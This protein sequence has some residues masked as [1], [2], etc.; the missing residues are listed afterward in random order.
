MFVVTVPTRV[1][2]GLHVRAIGA[3]RAWRALACGCVCAG[4]LA[5]HALAAHAAGAYV[6]E[7]TGQYS[8]HFD[9]TG[10]QPGHGYSNEAEELFSWDVRFGATAAGPRSRQ[11]VA[12]L[13]AGGIDRFAR[14]GHVE[15][16]DAVTC[17]IAPS[18]SAQPSAGYFDVEPG[19]VAGTVNVRAIIP[20]LTGPTGQVT[21]A[22]SSNDVCAGLDAAGSAV[23][24]DPFGCAWECVDFA[25]NPAFDEAWAISLTGAPVSSFPRSFQA[26]EAMSPCAETATAYSAERS[27]SATLDILAVGSS[28]KP[29]VKPPH[30]SPAREPHPRTSHRASRRL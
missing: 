9:Q 1:E 16:P 15:D 27:L 4:W 14:A 3:R 23:N 19:A 17:T 13:S 11:A 2:R 7:Y 30:R 25:A 24:C 29:V 18:P 6:G 8:F 28:G 20:I 21:V 26:S 10:L 22:P 5:F 12:S